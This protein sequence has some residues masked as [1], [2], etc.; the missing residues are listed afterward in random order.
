MRLLLLGLLTTA[1]L[2]TAPL[3]TAPLT[4]APFTTALLTMHG[5]RGVALLHP[6]PCPSLLKAPCRRPAL[7]CRVPFTRA[8]HDA[9]RR[10]TKNGCPWG[11]SQRHRAI[12]GRCATVGRYAN[13]AWPRAVWARSRAVPAIVLSSSYMWNMCLVASYVPLLAVWA[14]MGERRKGQ[15]GAPQIPTSPTVSIRHGTFGSATAQHSPVRGTRAN[16]RCFA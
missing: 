8:A 4:T 5:V 11:S 9:A 16:V 6:I 15:K 3:T 7:P 2:T 1:L 10:G 13:S 12:V 14:L